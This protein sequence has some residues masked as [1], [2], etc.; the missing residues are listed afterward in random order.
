[1]EA[2]EVGGRRIGVRWSRAGLDEEL[3]RLARSSLGVQDAPPNLSVVVGETSGRTSTK[4]NLYVQGQLAS[5]TRSEGA[6]V[7]AIIRALAAL[8]TA[9]PDDTLTINAFLL[10]DPMG[11]VTAVDR[12]LTADFRH[13]EPRLRRSGHRAVDAPHLC[14]RPEA[15]TVVL[16]DTRRTVAIELDELDRRWPREKW[17]DDLLAG[18]LALSRLVYGGHPDPQSLS[19]AVADMVSLVRDARGRVATDAVV[20]LA[21]LAGR[22]E[23][24]GVPGQDPKTL[25]RALG[26]R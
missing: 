18:D 16:P 12:R 24:E 26:I 14:V 4:H 6:L 17:D 13:L 1:M 5:T 25:S 10:I 19:A 20:L 2:Y 3:R 23:T 15:P 22:V 8:G 21:E 7:R 11:A 9:I